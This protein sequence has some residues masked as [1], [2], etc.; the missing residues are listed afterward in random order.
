MISI[1]GEK[2]EYEG[3]LTVFDML[4]KRRFVFPLLIVR[5]NGK[6][7]NRNS[8]KKTTISDEDRIDVIHM[9]SGG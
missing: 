4:E 9:M 7:V 8:Y 3:S 1:N 6:L 5:I 2:V